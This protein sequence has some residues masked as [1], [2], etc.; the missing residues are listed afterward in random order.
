MPHNELPEAGSVASWLRTADGDIYVARM[1]PS[2]NMLI[3]I[4][5]YHAQQAA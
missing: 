3:E 2:E 5:C 4:L 1:S